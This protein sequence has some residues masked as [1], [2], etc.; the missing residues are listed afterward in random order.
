MMSRNAISFSFR[1]PDAWY[2]GAPT[3]DHFNLNG[4]S[5]VKNEEEVR[6]SIMLN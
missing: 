4:C 2:D 5:Y 6:L 3:V 1:F